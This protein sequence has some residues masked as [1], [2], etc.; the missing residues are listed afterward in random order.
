MATGSFTIPVLSAPAVEA[1]PETRVFHFDPHRGFT[2]AE[3]RTQIALAARAG[4]NVILFPVFVNGYTLFPCAATKEIRRGRGVSRFYPINPQYRKWDPVADATRAAR[5]AG[6]NLWGF[7]RPYN[8]HPRYSSA[9]HR[10]LRKFPEWRIAP[11]PLYRRHRL[12]S[13][14][15][16]VACPLNPDYRRYLGDMLTELAE[17]YAVDGLVINYTGFGLRGGTITSYPYC[18]CRSCRALYAEARKGDLLNDALKPEGLEPIRKWQAEASMESVEYLRHRL[19]KSRRTLRLICRAQPQWRTDP[20]ETGTDM[21]SEYSLDWNTMLETGTVEELLIDHD[22]ETAPDLFRNRLVSDLAALRDEAFI[23][24]AVRVNTAEDLERPLDA[25][26]RYPVAGFLAEFVGKFAERD[27]D[28]IRENY[29]RQDAQSPD[30]SPLAATQFFLRRIQ[31]RHRDNGLISDFMRDFIRLIEAQ[32]Q[33][34][35]TFDTLQIVLDNLE[36][37]Q[38]AIRRGRLGEY[39]IPETTMRDISLARKTTRLACLDVRT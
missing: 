34:G 31:T 15:D 27:A 17:G 3:V 23:L 35:M 6:V 10:L 7:V 4:F 26:R 39:S 25:V 5:D 19:I 11:H 32:Q 33:K 29:L 16:I 24:P 22:D 8:F 13:R 21:Q 36:G 20:E 1:V 28:F 14:E 38:N 37:L 12:K 18:F 9:T 30:Q 2:R